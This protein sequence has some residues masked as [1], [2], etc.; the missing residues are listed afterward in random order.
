MSKVPPWAKAGMGFMA[1]MHTRDARRKASI[2][3]VALEYCI[4]I[5]LQFEW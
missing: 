5:P 1:T 2:D 4:D 3:V